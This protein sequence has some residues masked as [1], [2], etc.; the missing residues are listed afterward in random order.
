MKCPECGTTI[1]GDDKFCGNC[2]AAA[3][4]EADIPT[5][6]TPDRPAEDSLLTDSEP[7]E[8]GL[9]EL[10]DHVAFEAEN[11]SD[12]AES[13]LEEIEPTLSDGEVDG[14]EIIPPLIEDEPFEARVQADADSAEFQEIINRDD[15]PFMEA[16][17][18]PEAD[19]GPGPDAPPAPP[20]VAKAKGKTNTGLII[21]IIV[22][23][24]LLLCCCCV[25][26]IGLAN[27][28]Q[29]AAAIETA[30]EATVT[31]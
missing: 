28:D 29:I 4:Q 23:V 11:L 24:L 15:E 1:S 16:A 9:D 14:F 12:D 18:L 3:P 22:L 7:V 10:A 30:I 26:G 2:G 13:A 20:P 25:L 21:G 6:E 19:F 31:P 8:G 17:P 5:S 27:F